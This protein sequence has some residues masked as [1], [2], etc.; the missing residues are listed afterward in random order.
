MQLCEWLRVSKKPRLTPTCMCVYV[1]IPRS[2]K[3]GRGDG[4][5]ARQ[6][7][8]DRVLDPDSVEDRGPL[9]G[10]LDTFQAASTLQMSNP[11]SSPL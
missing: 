2:L 3:P 7:V 6:L 4:K 1:C 11:L 9:S 5:H 10:R 8:S